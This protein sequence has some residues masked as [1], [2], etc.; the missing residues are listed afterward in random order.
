MLR[1]FTQGLHPKFL[2]TVLSPSLQGYL[3]AVSFILAEGQVLTLVEV[4]DSRVRILRE[5]L[6]FQGRS[7]WHLSRY[8]KQ[9]ISWS[10]LIYCPVGVMGF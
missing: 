4:F 3:P 2:T 9:S 8:A 5:I 1:V 10:L 6:Q 7:R